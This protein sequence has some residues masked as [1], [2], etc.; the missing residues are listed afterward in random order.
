MP[1]GPRRSRTAGLDELGALG[2]QVERGRR[3]L[4][5]T[6][7]DLADLAGVSVDTVHSVEAGKASVRLDMVL[8]VL[9]ALGLALV[10]VT[11]STARTL[12]R[13]GDAAV[14]ERSRIRT[15]GSGSDLDAER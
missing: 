14:L 11:R 12:A 10:A 5:L 1:T 2:L 6:Q 13:T 15:G 8:A 3:D 7:R 9:E 4:Q